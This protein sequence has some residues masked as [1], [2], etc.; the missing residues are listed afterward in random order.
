MSKLQARIG[1]ICL[2]FMML[3]ST[4]VTATSEKFSVTTVGDDG[5]D[6]VDMSK[7][8]AAKDSVVQVVVQYID[9]NSDKYL[10]KSGSGF[11]INKTTV[12]TAYDNVV[13]SANEKEIASQYLTDETGKEVKLND[14]SGAGNSC[15]IGISVYKDVVF[16]ASLSPYSSKE[17]NIGILTL[18]EDLNREPAL[19][20][21]SDD[22]EYQSDLYALGF[23]KLAS[24]S[25]NAELL[26]GDDC[27][28]EVGAV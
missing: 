20:G 23:R 28:E 13:L 17:M 3:F 2:V 22:L 10:L 27:K 6:R 14:E 8:E 19:L 24:M 18:T 9:G 4:N 15:Q 12:V 26:S 7:V 5:G 25:K 16:T 1:C 11:L 21:D